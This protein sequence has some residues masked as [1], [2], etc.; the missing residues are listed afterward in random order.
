MASSTPRRLQSQM[1]EALSC[2][3]C[4]NPY[5]QDSRLPKTFPCLHTVCLACANE[6]CQHSYTSTLSCPTCRQP[7]CI[8]SQG[9]SGLPTNLDVRNMVEIIQKTKTSSMAN[10]DCS[11]HPS[12]PI[13]NICV[14]CK[15]G[16]CTKCFTS[17]A[18]KQHS[19]HR[20]LEIH[21]AFDKIKETCDTLTKKG[22]EV[23]KLLS[24]ESRNIETKKSVL[25]ALPRRC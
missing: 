11:D 16:L 5:D 25:K 18:M 24:T 19:D 2:I 23:C 17:S 14:T 4:F 21:D 1:V 15:V 3:I 13:S 9:A 10:P 7:V 6:L 12:R 8:P 20:V 22:R